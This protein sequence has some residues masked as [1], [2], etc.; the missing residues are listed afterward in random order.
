M[1][2]ILVVKPGLTK[3]MGL[4]LMISWTLLSWLPPTSLA[5]RVGPST[6]LV[7]WNLWRIKCSLFAYRLAL[8]LHVNAGF[9]SSSGWSSMKWLVSCTSGVYVLPHTASTHSISRSVCSR[10]C[11]LML[12]FSWFRDASGVGVVCWL[13][14]N[15]YSMYCLRRQGKKPKKKTRARFVP[16]SFYHKSA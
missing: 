9:S 11:V 16:Q 14:N 15:S 1:S 12:P 13:D 10:V 8:L 2:M 4:W 3:L 5:L 6:L 7:T